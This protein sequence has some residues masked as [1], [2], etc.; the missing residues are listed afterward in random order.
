MTLPDSDFVL[1]SDF[2]LVDSDFV[3]VS[4]TL[5]LRTPHA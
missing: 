3:L 5:A 1:I 4:V 2:V